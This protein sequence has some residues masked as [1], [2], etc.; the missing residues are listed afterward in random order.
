MTFQNLF[1]PDFV[2]FI[3]ALNIA[4]VDYVLVGGYSVNLHGHFRGTGDMDIWVNPTTDNYQK[5]TNAFYHFGLSIFDMSLEKFLNIKENDVF[6]F[7]RKPVSIDI[8]TKVKGLVFKSSFKDSVLFEIDNDI[9]VRTVSLLD[10]I[11]AK[12]AS[13]RHKDLDDI[14][15]LES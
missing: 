8:M 2:D 12:K 5:L 15:H 3:K 13:G 6:T 7:G 9:W 1:N 11:K 4:K 10:L 14:E